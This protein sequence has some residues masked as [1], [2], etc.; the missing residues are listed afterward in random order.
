MLVGTLG[1]DRRAPRPAAVRRRLHARER[2]RRPDPVRLRLSGARPAR[3][4]RSAPRGGRAAAP[5]RPA[6]RPLRRARHRH[7]RHRRGADR[8]LATAR[9]RAS[10]SRSCPRSRGS[11][12]RRPRACCATSRR[13][14]TG[15]ATCSDDAGL[16]DISLAP[17]VDGR[18]LRSNGVDLQLLQLL[19]DD[20]RRS[21]LELGAMHSASASRWP[22]GAWRRSSRPA[23]CGSPRSSIRIY[24]GTTWRCFIWMRVEL[25]RLEET[26]RRAGRA[27]RGP[28][29]LGHERVQRPDLRGD[30]AVR[31]TTSTSSRPTCSACCPASGRW[32]SALELATVQ[33]RV[34]CGWTTTSP[35]RRSDGSESRHRSTDIRSAEPGRSG[36][37]R[38]P[39]AWARSLRAAAATTRRRRRLPPRPP[40]PFAAAGAVLA[41]VDKPVNM[42]PADAQLYSSMQ[43]YQNIFHK[44]VNVDADFKFIPGPGVEVD[45]GRREDVDARARRQRRLPQRRAVHRQGRQVQLRPAARA[46]QRDLRAGVE[47]DRGRRRPHACASTSRSRTAPSWRRW[48]RSATW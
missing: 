13:R 29:P 5:R 16:T 17:A 46:R 11:R 42:D 36:S 44:L 25:A 38:R 4:A 20:G 37:W 23:A 3:A 21:V 32:M 14:T 1:V 40:R 6:R 22:D 12:A 34:T 35:R 27:A 33:A 8:P 43:V 48:R 18:L 9:S 26:R 15:A 39:A 19:V 45:A 10:C 2:P 24:S 7:V 28:L 30:P 47:G 31:R 41:T